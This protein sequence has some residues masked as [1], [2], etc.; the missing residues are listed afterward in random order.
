MKLFEKLLVISMFL[1]VVLYFYIEIPYFVILVSFNAIALITNRRILEKKYY[2]KFQKIKYDIRLHKVDQRGLI[3]K[4]ISNIFSII[5]ILAPSFFDFPF[6]TRELPE[7]SYILFVGLGVLILYMGLSGLDGSF[8]YFSTDFIVEPGYDLNRVPWNTITGMDI[9]KDNNKF[10][11]NFKDG[12]TI[13]FDMDKYYT[14]LRNEDILNYVRN[15]IT[16]EEQLFV[17]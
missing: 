7:N 5:L 13:L 1:L 4:T 15:R 17:Y 3:G 2:E 6:E 16:A 14:G 10:W 12:S 9:S 11:L 8:Y